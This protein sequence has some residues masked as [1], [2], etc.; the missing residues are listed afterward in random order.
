[1]TEREIS[2]EFNEEEVFFEEEDTQKEKY[3]TFRIARE[4]FAIEIKYVREIIR[5]Q[6]ITAVP[7]TNAYVEGVINL[8]GK[9]IPVVDV[10][11]RFGI[12]SREYDDRTCIVVVSMEDILTGLIVD[13][14]SEV[15]DIPD[16]QIDPAPGKEGENRFI[17]GMGKVDEQVKIILDVGKVLR[18]QCI[19]SIM[20]AV[21]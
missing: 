12:D 10:R 6:K 16:Q 4:D 20:E 1:M 13:R 19:R 5:I 8:R 9:V 15:L 14:V 21:E 3:L 17:K 7:E 2:S 18:D 11:K